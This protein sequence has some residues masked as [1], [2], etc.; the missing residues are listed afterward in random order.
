MFLF[1][2][3][4]CESAYI[5]LIMVILNFHEAIWSDAESPNVDRSI[6]QGHPTTIFLQILPI[7][8]SFLDIWSAFRPPQINFKLRLKNVYLF[9][10]SRAFSGFFVHFPNLRAVVDRCCRS[11]R[12]SVSKKTSSPLRKENSLYIFHRWYF[13][14]EN[15]KGLQTF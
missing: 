7:K 6:S 14:K 1:Y 2:K 11:C 5:L 13:T 4:K 9:G 8:R 12:F 3:S 10:H 15:L